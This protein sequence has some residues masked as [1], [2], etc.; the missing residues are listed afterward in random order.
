MLFALSQLAFWWGS[1]QLSDLKQI[2]SFPEPETDQ[3]LRHGDLQGSFQLKGVC[4][5]VGSSQLA[6][7]RQPWHALAVLHLG[8][9]VPTGT[10]YPAGG[11]VAGLSAK[12]IDLRFRNIST[13]FC[14]FELMLSFAEF[15]EVSVGLL[16]LKPKSP[17]G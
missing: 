8:P 10:T 16:V 2:P 3:V 7:E 15:G 11:E 9:L 12:L 5:T 4:I 17:G 1:S 13:F 6:P 14:L